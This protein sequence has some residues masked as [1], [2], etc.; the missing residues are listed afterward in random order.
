[1]ARKQQYDVI[2]PDGIPIHHSDRYPTKKAAKAAIKE[3]VKRYEQQGYYSSKDGRI[4]LRGL[5]KCC[6]IVTVSVPDPLEHQLYSAIGVAE[7]RLS[8]GTDINDAFAWLKEDIAKI[9]K[10]EIIYD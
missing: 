10:G 9:L 6:T 2:S 1:M 3:W 5:P 4:P 8:T 7:G